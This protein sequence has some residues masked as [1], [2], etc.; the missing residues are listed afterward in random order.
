MTTDPLA[1]LAILPSSIYF[2]VYD[3]ASGEILRSGFC[4]P[5]TLQNQ[6]ENVLYLE[7]RPAIDIDMT[8]YILDSALTL[9]PEFML[10]DLS[11]EIGEVVEL[12]V[13]PGTSVNGTIIEDGNIDLS[14]D[15][16]DEY[17]LELRFF[18]FLPKTIKVTVNANEP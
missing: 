15:I 4:N 13:P 10:D 9:R 16:V 8:H 14:G 2:L 17:K 6:G 18:P 12:V 1:N 5:L 7:E 11:L 3:E